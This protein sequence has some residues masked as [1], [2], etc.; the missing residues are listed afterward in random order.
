MRIALCA[1]FLVTLLGCDREVDPECVEKPSP[2]PVACT[3]ELNPVCGCN[4]K[5]YDN[6]CIAKAYGITRYTPGACGKN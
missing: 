6:P 4:G 2:D 3:Y 5:T 1:V